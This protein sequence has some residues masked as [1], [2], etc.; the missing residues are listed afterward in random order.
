M[1]LAAGAGFFAIVAPA[2]SGF[3][4]GMAVF[5]SEPAFS[6]PASLSDVMTRRVYPSVVGESDSLSG[7]GE[8]DSLSSASDGLSTE[9]RPWIDIPLAVDDARGGYRLDRFLAER[10]RRLSRTRIQ[11]IIAAGNVVRRDAPLQPLRAASRVHAGETVIVRRPAPIEPVVPMHAGVIHRCAELLVLDKPAGLPVHPSARYHRHTLTAVLRREFGTAHGWTMAHRLDRETS[12]VMVFGRKGKTDSLLK[13][14]FQE[15]R[16]TKEYLAI[17]RGTL[18]DP[19]T[20]ELP[21]GPA[22]G[23]RIRIKMGPRS[24]GDGGLPA[25]TEV[26][27]LSCGEYRGESITLVRASPRTGR[28]HQIRV[29]LAELGHPVLGDKLYGIDEQAFLDVADHIRL[30]SDL[31]AELGLSRQALH[32]AAI[33]IPHPLEPRTLVFTAPWPPELESILADPRAVAAARCPPPRP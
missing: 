29:H 18:R 16:V 7:A 27:P 8:T 31:E 13:R 5:A 3:A 23:S 10:I 9:G 2:S 30:M 25:C 1:G 21:I 12:G 14:A 11:S 32:A 6:T 33:T 28:Q 22:M 20:V 24:I 4:V 19:S 17:V 26:E 15:R